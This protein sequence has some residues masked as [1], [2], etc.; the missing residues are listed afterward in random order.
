MVFPRAYVRGTR[1]RPR[2]RSLR[3]RCTTLAAFGRSLSRGRRGRR[4]YLVHH[5]VVAHLS[6]SSRAAIRPHCSSLPA[7]GRLPR[8]AS[9][10]RQER[11]GGTLL[12]PLLR[13]PSA[14][15]GCRPLISRLHIVYRLARCV[16]RSLRSLAITRSSRSSQAPRGH[17][18]VPSLPLLDHRNYGDGLLARCRLHISL[19]VPRRGRRAP[20]VSGCHPRARGCALT[21]A[22][23]AFARAKV[24]LLGVA[25]SRRYRFARCGSP[26]RTIA[27][28]TLL[29][30]LMFLCVR[31]S[32]CLLL[33]ASRPFDG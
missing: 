6:R 3:S 23:L 32:P 14:L 12:A 17:R 33:G 2:T 29:R 10:R 25:V 16:A 9:R 5:A 27:S 26:A 8:C 13:H 20:G 1:A 28:G 15:I 21:G 22:A 31:A 7:P 11:P 24:C 4:V 30:P 19:L 18:V